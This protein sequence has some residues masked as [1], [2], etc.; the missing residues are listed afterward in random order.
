MTLKCL[1]STLSP[2][3]TAQDQKKL[4]MELGD[5]LEMDVQMVKMNT[6]GSANP[7][8]TFMKSALRLQKVAL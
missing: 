6:T 4:N 1:I 3:K 2:P 5:N 7:T 8:P